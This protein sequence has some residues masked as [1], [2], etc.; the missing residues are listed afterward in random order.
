MNISGLNLKME[1]LETCEALG[2]GETTVG[3]IV[4]VVIVGGLVYGGVCAV[5]T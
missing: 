5:S 2:G 1:E 4:G 3:A